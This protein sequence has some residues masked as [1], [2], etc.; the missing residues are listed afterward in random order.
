MKTTIRLFGEILLCSYLLV[1]CSK[2]DDLIIPTFQE[3]NVSMEDNIADET[4]GCYYNYFVTQNDSDHTVWVQ[5]SNGFTTTVFSY[6]IRPGEQVTQWTLNE[7][8]PNHI[9]LVEDLSVMRYL[10]L[11][12][13]AP[14]PEEMEVERPQ[15]PIPTHGMDTCA[16]YVFKQSS[17]SSVAAYMDES[18]WQYEK[19]NDHRVRWTY[20][21]TNAD[22]G[23]AVQQTLE[24]WADKTQDEE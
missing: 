20:R 21:I 9:V 17:A 15:F 8:L 10:K 23:V 13:N 6:Y 4:E 11:F 1:G 19:F 14:S 5:L 3:V 7:Y 12:F 22:H 2:S 16:K 24:R 18:R